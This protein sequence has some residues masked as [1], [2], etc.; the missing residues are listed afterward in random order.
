MKNVIGRTIARRLESK[1]GVRRSTMSVAGRSGH[2][3][4]RR[5]SIE[6]LDELK[7]RLL[8]ERAAAEAD[9]VV[10]VKLLRVASL[11][12]MIRRIKCKG[13]RKRLCVPRIEALPRFQSGGA[14]SD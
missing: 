13:K 6:S 5:D 11:R 3:A 4:R 2:Y 9:P 14:E 7:Q 1:F 10:I 8:R 12:V